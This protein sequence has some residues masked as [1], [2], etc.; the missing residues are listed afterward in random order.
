MSPGRVWIRRAA[1]LGTMCALALGVPP[2][3]LSAQRAPA[4]RFARIDAFLDS[5]VR[6]ETIGG[7]VALILDDGRPIYHRAVGWQDRE[8]RKPMA[9]TSLFRTA[10]HTKALTSVVI[11]GLVDEG[12][13]ALDDPASRW[14]PSFATTRVAS[15]DGSVVQARRPITIRDLLT[16]TSGISYGVDDPVAAAHEAIGLGPGAG[17]GLGWYLADKDEPI[18]ATVERL[19]RAPFVAQPGE[20]WVYGYSTDVLGC[21]AE[22]VAGKPLDVLIR[23]RITGPLGMRDTY[24]YVPRADADRLAVVYSTGSDGRVVRAPL[25]P[26][27]QGDFVEGPRRSFSG[28]SGLVS[29]AADYARFLEAI[30][31]GGELDGVRILSPGMVRLMVTNQVGPLYGRAG[32]GWG[33]AFETVE[34]F[35]EAGLDP[36]GSYGWSGAYGSI[37]KVDPNDG[38]VI[39][40]LTQMLPLQNAIRQRFVTVAF[41]ALMDEAR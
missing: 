21:I 36:A 25:G 27:G 17:A 13:I 37:Y 9:E 2:T 3:G 29:T 38:I 1:S 15:P 11:L 16:H 8:A 24:F 18:C 22:R 28:G 20:S 33:L 35:G 19:P 23:E 4:Q 32:R 10:S 6:A 34:R 14:I 26:R 30:R 31:N 39:V 41:Q 40:F 7:A 12:R 5:L